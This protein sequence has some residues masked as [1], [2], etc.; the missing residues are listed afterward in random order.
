MDIGW[1]SIEQIQAQSFGRVTTNVLKVVQR[2]AA[3]QA[4]GLL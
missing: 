1:F 4:A 2:A 3:L